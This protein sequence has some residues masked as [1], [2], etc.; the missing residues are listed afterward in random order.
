MKSAAVAL[1]LALVAVKAF[2]QTIE[3]PNGDLLR[4]PDG[5]F[6]GTSNSGG[7]DTYGTIFRLSAQ[8]EITV[9]AS[10][11][12]DVGLAKGAYP[13][14][15][16]VRDAA[17]TLWGT[18]EQGGAN[19][20]GTVFKFTPSNRKL[21]TVV[22][23][24]GTA[25]G[26]R[27]AAALVRDAAGDFIGTASTGGSGDF[28]TIFK[29]NKTTGAL[30]TLVEF[31]GTG[32]L[33]KGSKPLGALFIDGAGVI[34]GTTSAGGAGGLGTVFKF[35]GTT[36]TTIAEFTG[37]LA[38]TLGATPEAALILSGGKLWGT[39]ASGGSADL[40]TV[41]TIDPA[42]LMFSSIASFTGPNGANPRA[43]LTPGAAGKLLGTTENGGTDDL[44]TIFS[45]DTA[46][47]NVTTIASF[48][49]AKGAA[50]GAHPVGGLTADSATL[51]FGTAT[52][53]GREDTGLV[54]SIDTTTGAG[55]FGDVVDSNPAPGPKPA[56]IK[57]PDK[58]LTTGPAGSTIP[59]GGALPDDPGI[60]EVL[61]SI[62]DGPFITA[63][64][65]AGPPPT[66]SLAVSPENGTN[67]IVI[68]TVNQDG[69]ISKPTTFSFEF[70]TVDPQ[71]VGTYSGL[72]VSAD[73]LNPFPLSGLITVNVLST[74]R[75]TGK[76][77]LGGL[78]AAI[79]L[80]GTFANSGVARF[81][82]TASPT[83]VIPRKK[84]QSPLALDLSLDRTVNHSL[85]GSIT[86]NSASAATIGAAQGLYTAKKN[87]VAPLV[88]VPASLLDA[89]AG[90]GSFTGVFRALP[91]TPA[92]P[93]EKFPQGDGIATLKIAPNGTVKVVAK[94]ADGTSVS[95][96]GP[97]VG[98]DTLPFFAFAY[99]G[100]GAI[101]GEIQFRDVPMQTDAAGAALLWFRPQ[102]NKAKNYRDGWSSGIAVDFEGSKYFL[103]KG[104]AV[105][106]LGNAPSS[107]ARN[108]DL[109]LTAGGIPPTTG[110]QLAIGVG[111]KTLVLGAITGGTALGNL[112]VGLSGTGGVGGTF[113]HP[114]TTLPTKLV[115]V[116]LQKQK[117]AAGYFLA[118]PAK[119]SPPTETQTS[120]RLEI[121]GQ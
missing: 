110:N 47:G 114:V 121:I 24:D 76:L 97:L 79:A 48:N 88:S 109:T 13:R 74:G 89:A 86:E 72:V 8:T 9:L 22:E 83:L 41:F 116:V 46:T 59:L 45:L 26:S 18:T 60:T 3:A 51:F 17:G 19:S 42:T 36:F 33:F 61:V 73:N 44:G 101:T 20:L 38:G 27:P 84:G 65:N 49:G 77:V 104:G 100:R 56:S 93:P 4:L 10:F 102:L 94:L 78:K 112:K 32:G 95:T 39:T 67:V 71:I 107:G 105:T 25:H 29:V 58:A 43:A 21:T 120:G 115:G 90:K 54:Y 52:K 55:T 68:K 62:N 87:P 11:T 23:F 96:S 69:G 15:G 80:K 91:P 6:V 92:L 5:T 34:W 37:T 7:T 63:I 113:V 108:A 53:G 70:T 75:F 66:W 28:G 106:P 118:S 12:G 16:L 50:P 103:P 30:T 117:T 111:G 64:I 98:A 119:G 31:T 35:D 81:G 14:A 99:G 85:T 2:A 1:L 82:K 57:A 40:G